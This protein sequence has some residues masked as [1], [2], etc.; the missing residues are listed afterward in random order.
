MRTFS[1][2]RMEKLAVLKGQ[3]E[4]QP[5]FDPE[6]Y[7]ASGFGFLKGG[8]D[9]RVEIEFDRWGADLLQANT[10]HPSQKIKPLAQGRVRMSLQLD[11]LEEIINWLMSW[12]EH[13]TVIAPEELRQRLWKIARTLVERYKSKPAASP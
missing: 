11:S 9:Y 13:A 5:D 3:F 1:L 2:S 10:W 8:G 12:G 6:K 4:R 7:F